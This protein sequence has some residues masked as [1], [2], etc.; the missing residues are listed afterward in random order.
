MSDLSKT[1][2]TILKLTNIK[3]RSR[4][5]LCKKLYTLIGSSPEQVYQT[6]RELV[7]KNWLTENNETYKSNPDSNFYL[8]PPEIDELLSNGKALHKVITLANSVYYPN[9]TFEEFMTEH[10]KKSVDR[11]YV[12]RILIVSYDKGI[13]RGL[14][15]ELRKSGFNYHLKQGKRRLIRSIN[16]IDQHP[17]VKLLGVIVI[18]ATFLTFAFNLFP[19]ESKTLKFNKEEWD[20]SLEFSASKRAKMVDDLI[21]NHLYQGM[22]YNNVK[23]LLGG[24]DLYRTD[25]PGNMLYSLYEDYGWD[26]DPI[27]TKSLTLTFSDSLLTTATHIHWIKNGEEITRRLKLKQN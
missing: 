23:E 14:P 11:D 24:K 12:R 25:S 6:L 15:I 7:A 2:R 19:S 17:I 26:I 21:Q 5:Y 16:W 3:P 20:V 9:L 1:E 27:E 13:V 18:I 10:L 22:H 8:Y 4:K